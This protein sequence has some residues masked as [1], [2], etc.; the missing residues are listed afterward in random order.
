MEPINFLILFAVCC[1]SAFAGGYI[2]GNAKAMTR[3]EE[4]RRWWRERERRNGQ[5]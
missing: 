1:T 3:A 4:M 2:L 5:C